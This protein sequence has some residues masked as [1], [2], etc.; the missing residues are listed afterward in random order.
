MVHNVH[1]LRD[2]IPLFRALRDPRNSIVFHVDRKVHLSIQLGHA[3]NATLLQQALQALQEEMDSCPCGSN[4]HIESVHEVQWSQWTMNLPTLWGMQ[5]AIDDPRFQNKW[6]VFINL[7]G[8]TYPVY[9]PST[10][11][12]IFHHLRQYN[13]VTSRSCETG[14]VPTNVYDFPKNW[15][16]R[17]HY[18]NR[19]QSP[20][21]TIHYN[22]TPGDN[23]TPTNQTINYYFGSQWV[24]LQPDF[25]HHLVTELARPD[26]FVSR[27]RDHLLITK[28]VMTDETFLPTLVMHIPPFN[29]TLPRVHVEEGPRKGTVIYDDHENYDNNMDWLLPPIRV[30]RYERMDERIPSPLRGYFP[31]HPRYEVPP[32]PL[33]LPGGLDMPPQPHTWGPYYLGVYDLADIVDSGALFLRKV[34]SLIDPNLFVLL[35]VNTRQEIPRIQWPSAGIQ[36]SA[37]PN[38]KEE[39]R[40]LMEHAVQNAKKQGHTVP[41]KFQQELDA[42]EAEH[43]SREQ[44]QPQPKLPRPESNNGVQPNMKTL[45]DGMNPID[46]QKIAAD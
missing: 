20:P 29:T 38:W 46:Q 36:V 27:Y 32:S 14:L 10:M 4:V 6:D 16:K 34:S 44:E 2:A 40:L 24:A 43:N 31:K 33:L 35:P 12:H 11:A 18:T 8:D 7:S 45:F 42:L 1:T 3:N 17:V 21:P 28:K 22:A 30:L 39:K 19:D 5:L 25:V 13:F 15:H 9:T 23:N 41:V 37:V 26:S